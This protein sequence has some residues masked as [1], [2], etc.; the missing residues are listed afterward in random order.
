M[1]INLEMQCNAG[2]M[3]LEQGK[4]LAGGKGLRAD[5]EDH[6]DDEDGSASAEESIGDC[7]RR[8]ASI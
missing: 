4:G 1:H 3:A 5:H 8:Q 6:D 7:G 2:C